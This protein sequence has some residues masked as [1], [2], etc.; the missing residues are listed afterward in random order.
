[1][2]ESPL[3]ASAKLAGWLKGGGSVA[4]TGASGWVG[5]AMTHLALEVLGPEAPSRLRLLGS[6]ERPFELLGQAMP[7]E[8][9]DKAAPLGPGEWLV[10][11]LAVVGPKRMPDAE[12]RRAINE[13]MLADALA[14][15]ATGEVR[16]FVSASSGA[17]ALPAQDHPDRQAYG[18]LKR[19]KEQ[20]V[21]AWSARTGVPALF[22]RIYNLGGPYMNHAARYV[23]GNFIR[24]TLAG[25][26]VRIEAP[27]PVLRSYVH[28]LEFARVTYDLALDAGPT[29]AF[30]TAGTEV[31]EL[32][33]L[34]A[35]VGRALGRPDLAIERP[36]LETE[37]PDSYVGDGNVY[38]AALAAS[39]AQQAG[40]ERIVRDTAA[41]LQASGQVG[42]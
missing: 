36:P 35:A 16:R 9:L 8:S 21:R 25:G 7:L 38:R 23:L 2:S 42:D 37:A 4:I 31:L 30:D 19:D 17:V 41:W 39:G 27:R 29:Q 22:P 18:D 6:S 1:M 12:R 3:Q 32:S 11:H 26:A 28:V 34:A 14:L 10:L 24:Q 33:E 20:I 40:I 13:A 5:R 15:A